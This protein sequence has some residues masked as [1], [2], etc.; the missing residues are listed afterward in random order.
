M[1][2]ILQNILNI[3]FS[4]SHYLPLILCIW[5]YAFPYVHFILFILICKCY[6]MRLISCISFMCLILCLSFTCLILC[7]SFSISHLYASFYASYSIHLI[8]N[9]PLYT[10]HFIH[11]IHVSHFMH[12][13]Y[14]SRFM[15]LLFH[16]SIIHLILCILFYSSHS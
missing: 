11:L 9:I 6:T 1:P 7:L 4:A 5:L 14:V 15:P 13:I 10:S 16:I 12:R 2:L 3:S 8:L